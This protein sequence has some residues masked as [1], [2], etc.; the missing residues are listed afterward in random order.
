[1]NDDNVTPVADSLNVTPT[2]ASDVFRAAGIDANVT[3]GPAVST[4]TPAV[5]ARDV[6]VAVAEL[7]T[8]SRI[9]EPPGKARLAP[10]PMPDPA[11]VLSPAATVYSNTSA[12][13]PVPLT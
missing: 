2:D 6:N 11:A 1:V 7:P 9:N 12:V 5:D 3:V 10:I 4:L 13:V 8:T